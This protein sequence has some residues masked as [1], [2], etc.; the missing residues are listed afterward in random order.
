MTARTLRAGDVCEVVDCHRGT[1]EEQLLGERVTLV[2]PT[3]A[4]RHPAWLIDPCLAIEASGD[5]RVG[6]AFY[7][8]G[9]RIPIRVL[10]DA[11]LRPVE[12]RPDPDALWR[13]SVAGADDMAAI[14]DPK[15]QTIGSQ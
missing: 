15:R 9:D 4:G 5:A 2:A 6:A 11:Y 1:D 14:T 7:A 3:T 10:P 13:E 8:H 12:T